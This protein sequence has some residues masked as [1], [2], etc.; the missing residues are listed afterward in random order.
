MLGTDGL[1]Q[2]ERLPVRGRRSGETCA[3][4]GIPYAASP[5]DALRFRA[6]EPASIGSSVYDAAQFG[7]ACLQVD[8]AGV[9]SGSQDC[10]SLN[11]WVPEHAASESLPVALF[12]HGGGNVSGSSAMPAYDGREL[13]ARGRLVVVSA[14]YRLGALG[15]L[16]H[17]ELS[18]E[19]DPPSSGNYGL[20][21]QIAVLEWIRKNI[22]V[23]G[24]DRQR[25]L[26]FGQSAGARNLCALLVSPRAEGLFQRAVMQSGA[27]ELETL[28]ASETFGADVA[29]RAGCA[30]GELAASCLRTRYA[31]ELIK[32][33][34]SLPG[35]LESSGYNP[36]I[37]GSLVEAPPLEL[38]PTRPGQTP[39]L[40]M[41]NSEEV[42]HVVGEIA[43]EAAY[44]RWITAV[45]G[46][47]APQIL[48]VYPASAYASPKAALVAAITDGR[49]TCPARRTARQAS[50]GGPT[51]RL[52]FAQGLDHGEQAAFGAYHGLELSFVFRSFEADGH[53]PSPLEL[54]VSDAMI[55]AYS[56]FAYTGSPDEGILPFA[57]FQGGDQA[58]T[59]VDATPNVERDL[60]S[61]ECDF[62]D[63]LSP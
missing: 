28:A 44:E 25:V 6:P 55:D 49:Y 36:N 20:L 51:Y 11:V 19:S 52:Q 29:R 24:G 61:R 8:A 56:R 47:L 21:D 7:P 39:L 60:S 9:V 63:Q 42:G 16:A 33:L 3:F 2:T 30:D 23:F 10:L 27:C 54:G 4:K 46:D 22:G 34:P 26:V 18:A 37:D 50:P 15:Y 57:P 62:W 31:V 35:P 40:V 43:D 5:I 17:P 45:Y 38:L 13:A 58:Y 1:V 14:N 53:I 41:T 32:A 59:R 12:L 48:A